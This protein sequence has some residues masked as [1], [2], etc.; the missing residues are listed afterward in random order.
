MIYVIFICKGMV[1]LL[2]SFFFFQSMQTNHDSKVVHTQK[3]SEKEVIH[4]LTKF[5]NKEQQKRDSLD[6]I[7]YL[8]EHI[9]DQITRI[10]DN[11]IINQQNDEQNDEQ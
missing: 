5:L 4:K 10:R 9:I 2:E 6:S 11:L 7:V 1:F 8:K 3:I